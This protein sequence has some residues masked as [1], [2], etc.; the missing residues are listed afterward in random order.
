ME[1]VALT[2]G[3]SKTGKRKGNQKENPSKPPS[4]LPNMVALG[5]RV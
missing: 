2:E 3:V 4:D 1:F 5:G